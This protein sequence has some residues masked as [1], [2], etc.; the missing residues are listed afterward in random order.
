M[1]ARLSDFIQSYSLKFKLLNDVPSED[2]ES[3]KG[4]GGYGG[5]KDKGAMGMEIILNDVILIEINLTLTFD[6]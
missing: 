1:I 4:G 3:R 5:K 6:D 2:A